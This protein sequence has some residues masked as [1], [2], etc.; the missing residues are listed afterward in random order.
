[1]Q[2]FVPYKNVV[3][4]PQPGEWID[5]G[6]APDGLVVDDRVRDLLLRAYRAGEDRGIETG[7]AQKAAE[8]KRALGI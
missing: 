3:S 2:L 5:L 7:K 4:D 1:M 6:L 8:I